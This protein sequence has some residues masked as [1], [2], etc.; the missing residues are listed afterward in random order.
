MIVVSISTSILT[1]LFVCRFYDVVEKYT[2]DG[3]ESRQDKMVRLMTEVRQLKNDNFTLR[4]KYEKDTT[5]LAEENQRLRAE[6][7]DNMGFARDRAFEQEMEV[8]YS[9]VLYSMCI[10]IFV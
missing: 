6:L 1:V 8:K 2:S 9:I 3:L 4:D 5:L 10:H 7:T